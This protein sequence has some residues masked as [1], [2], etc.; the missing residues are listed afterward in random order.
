[1]LSAFPQWSLPAWQWG[2][3]THR[4]TWPMEFRIGSCQCPKTWYYRQT[5]VYQRLSHDQRIKIHHSCSCKLYVVHTRW[6][7]NYLTIDI[8]KFTDVTASHVLYTS[9]RKPLRLA[10][11]LWT[12]YRVHKHN[13]IE[14]KSTTVLQYKINLVLTVQ[15]HIGKVLLNV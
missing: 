6:R 14:K 9:T 12:S 13:N 7:R 15:C 8:F 11:L 4:G 3:S 2:N 10:Y 5:N 1:M